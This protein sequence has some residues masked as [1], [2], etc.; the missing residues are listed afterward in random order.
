M[1]TSVNTSECQCFL[2]NHM[3]SALKSVGIFVWSFAVTVNQIGLTLLKE[4]TSVYSSGKWVDFWKNSI[5]V[6]KFEFKRLA[7][8][9][10][11][12]R[13]AVIACILFR[14]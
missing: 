13:T 8:V 9:F 11:Q 7:I 10:K 1:L 4:G 12:L 6:L 3:V 14:F 2:N 5:I